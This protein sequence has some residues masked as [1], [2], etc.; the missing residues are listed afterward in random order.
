GQTFFDLEPFALTLSAVI[1]EQEGVVTSGSAV[2]LNEVGP[3]TSLGFIDPTLARQEF[4]FGRDQAV[5]GVNAILIVG[6]NGGAPFTLRSAITSG[7]AAEIE[8]PLGFTG[9]ATRVGIPSVPEADAGATLT[10]AS[11][12]RLHEP[13]DLSRATVT[14][15]RLLTELGGVGEL[16][17]GNGGANLLPVT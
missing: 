16:I 11:K 14:V 2:F 1:L 6:D 3:G 17:K 10:M 13:V 8:P 15:G 5:P 7:I 9:S 12:F 4:P